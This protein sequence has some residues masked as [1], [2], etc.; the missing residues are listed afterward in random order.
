MPEKLPPLSSQSQ[1]PSSNVTFNH[2]IY[3]N[4]GEILVRGA[5]DIVA[6]PQFVNFSNN[7]FRLKSNSPGIDKGTNFSAVKT[8]ITGNRRPSGKGFDIGAYEYQHSGNP[9]TNPT[10][11]HPGCPTN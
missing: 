5:N 10:T 9:T 8:D 1:H 2:N 4:G 3:A 7:D 6:D 11:P